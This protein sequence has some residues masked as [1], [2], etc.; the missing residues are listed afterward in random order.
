MTLQMQVDTIAECELKNGASYI[1]EN[2]AQESLPDHL[3]WSDYEGSFLSNQAGI[4]PSYF[5]MRRQEAGFFCARYNEWVNKEKGVGNE[6]WKLTKKSL[7]SILE[8]SI[9]S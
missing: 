4:L 9:I 3:K 1:L 6:C 5:F 2:R 8:D 7:Y